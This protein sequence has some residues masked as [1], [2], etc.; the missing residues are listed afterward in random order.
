MRKGMKPSVIDTT[1]LSNFAHARR[2]DLLQAALGADAFT[3][4]AVMAEFHAG[5]ERRLV[6]VCDW[7]WLPVLELTPDEIKLAAQLRQQLGAGEAQCLAVAVSRGITF[8]SDDFAARRMASQHG[9]RV[10]GTLGVL[11]HLVQTG[12]LALAEADDLLLTFVTH[13]YRSP[14]A[15]LRQLLHP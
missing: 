5:E 8:L 15:S 4:P 14:V 7:H 9:V 2:S 3:T 12:E 13:G 6:P 11:L 1:V 10:S